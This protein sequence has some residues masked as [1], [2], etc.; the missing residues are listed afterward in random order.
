MIVSNQINYC[1]GTNSGFNEFKTN[2]VN[3]KLVYNCF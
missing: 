3:V 2:S 1:F